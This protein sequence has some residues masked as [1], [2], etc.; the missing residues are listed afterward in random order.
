EGAGRVTVVPVAR[1]AGAVVADEPG[2]QHPHER[3]QLAFPILRDQRRKRTRHATERTSR[4]GRGDAF[5]SAI[6]PAS[7][8][9]TASQVREK[10]RVRFRKAETPPRESARL[11]SPQNRRTIG[12]VHEWACSPTGRR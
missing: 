1:R 6:G 11:V 10:G 9:F 8:G 4:S 5:P 7:G 2:R 3:Q 12:A